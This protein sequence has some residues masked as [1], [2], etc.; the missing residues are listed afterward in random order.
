M[1]N[2]SRVNILTSKW[3]QRKDFILQQ[4]FVSIL[5]DVFFYLTLTELKVPGE[6]EI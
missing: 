3:V 1:M 5:R 4:A 6:D 2:N